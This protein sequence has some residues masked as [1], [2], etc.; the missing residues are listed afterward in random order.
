MHTYTPS[1]HIARDLKARWCI[2]TYFVLFHF[3]FM[4]FLFLLFLVF[5]LL[6]FLV[7]MGFMMDV[8]TKLYRDMKTEEFYTL[9]EQLRCHSLAVYASTHSL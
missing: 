2:C 4:L 9:P 6:V 7:V 5:L 8:T 1:N 3:D